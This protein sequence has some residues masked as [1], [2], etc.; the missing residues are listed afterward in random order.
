MECLPCRDANVF[1]DRCSF[2]TSKKF[3]SIVQEEAPKHGIN[4]LKVHMI[5]SS[6]SKCIQLADYVAGACRSMYEYGDDSLEILSE[7]VS[8][9]RRR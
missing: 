6:D 1:L 9:A 3:R 4:P 5:S 7:K 8:F 2:L